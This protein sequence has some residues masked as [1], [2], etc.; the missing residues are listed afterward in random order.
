MGEALEMSFTM[1]SLSNVEPEEIVRRE[2][3]MDTEFE[4]G[5]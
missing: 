1:T 5:G 3:E 2:Y 4:R